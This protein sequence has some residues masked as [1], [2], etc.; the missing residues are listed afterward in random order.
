MDAFQSSPRFQPYLFS[1]ERVLWTRQPERRG[2]HGTRYLPDPFKPPGSALS[3]SGTL[4]FGRIPGRAAVLPPIRFGLLIVGLYFVIGFF[5]DAYVRKRHL[6]GYR[7]AR[8]WYRGPR[9]NR[10]TSIASHASSF[11]QHSNGIGTLAFEASNYSYWGG[12]RGLSWWVPS[13][14]S[15]IEFFR[16]RIHIKSTNSSESCRKADLEQ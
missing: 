7:P 5:H 10:S 14:S 1:G 15:A 12:M 13:L 16:V 8:Y 2:P 4:A 6:R 11:P 3:S 9:S